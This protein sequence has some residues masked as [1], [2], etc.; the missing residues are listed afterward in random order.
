MN[1][2]T[3][4]LHRTVEISKRISRGCGIYK[5]SA[6]RVEKFVDFGDFF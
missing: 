1:L 2:V 6:R 3:N 5:D 4:T